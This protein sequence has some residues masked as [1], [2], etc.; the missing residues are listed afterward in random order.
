VWNVDFAC[1]RDRNRRSGLVTH[2]VMSQL[3]L[4]L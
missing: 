2:L 1:D 4:Y 3:R